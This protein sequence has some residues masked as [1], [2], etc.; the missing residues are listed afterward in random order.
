MTLT[1]EAL[2]FLGF[3]LLPFQKVISLKGKSSPFFKYI[4]IHPLI[5]F[6]LYAENDPGRI[7]KKPVIVVASREGN[8]VDKGQG[9]EGDFSQYIIFW[10]V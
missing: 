6:C 5:C 8:W 7:Q 2:G 10:T 1:E 9:W 4:K 3:H